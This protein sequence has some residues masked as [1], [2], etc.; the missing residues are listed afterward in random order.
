MAGSA[1]SFDVLERQ[2]HL[3]RNQWLVV[4]LAA[5]GGMLEFLD[6]YVIAFVLAFIIG[7]WH[8]QY[9]QTA[10]VLLSSGVG[11]LLGSFFW[12]VLADRLGRRITFAAMIC[13]CGLAS[14]V[15]A[16]TP[17]GDWL[18]LTALRFIVG[19]GVGGFFVPIMLV[20]EFLPL[21]RRGQA[22]GIVSAATAGGLVLGALS[23]SFL[24]PIL[25]WRGMFLMGG[26]PLF[27][28]IAVY[29]ILRESPLWALAKHKEDMARDSL[30]WVL[31]PGVTPELPRVVTTAEPQTWH[32]V[33]RHPRSLLNGTLINL[34]VVTGYYGMVMWSPTLLTQIQGLSGE[35]A[36]TIM[37]GVSLAGLVARFIVGA[38]SDRYGRRACGAVA[39]IL[40]G[41][42]LLCTGWVG[43]GDLLEPHL[44]W[45][46]LTVSFIF[47]DASVAV[48]A[49][50]TAEIWAPPVRGR[51]S[52][53]SYAAG[54]L[55]KIIGPLGFALLIGSDN[56]IRPMTTVDTLVSSFGYLAG[57][58][59]LA[60]LV[61]ALIGIDTQVS[62]HAGR[63]IPDSSGIGGTRPSTSP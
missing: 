55:G 53:V 14:L 61:Y 56:V 52:G 1:Q 25:G 37:I 59:A 10:I 42:A 32:E 45:L 19:V 47:A 44:F 26:L 16:L 60:G 34:G 48:L 57:M 11:A 35:Q 33:L 30:A 24:A 20:Q 22:C 8:L 43:H 50:Y 28:G 38:L 29:F 40:T 13:T 27:F 21:R 23:G 15:L 4:V 54:G 39:G 9:G 6:A 49:A 18:F 36:A 46:P 5:I 58:F 17:E 51:G 31:P 2:E 63:P 41:A 7:P 3:T 12:G 62:V